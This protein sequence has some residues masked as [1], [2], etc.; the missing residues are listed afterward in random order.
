M[1]MSGQT[2]RRVFNWGG[3]TAVGDHARR[4][5]AYPTHWLSA[6]SDGCQYQDTGQV[7]CAREFTKNT[8][9]WYILGPM[10]RK[11]GMNLE[12]VSI[13]NS[14]GTL[15]DFVPIELFLELRHLFLEGGK[16]ILLGKGKGM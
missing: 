7:R 14:G 13:I 3:A 16:D 2:K 12:N 9:R 11:M 8:V 15:L 10:V 6:H 4:P 5:H 1:A